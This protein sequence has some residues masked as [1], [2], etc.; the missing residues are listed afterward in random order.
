MMSVTCG[1]KDIAPFQGLIM[2]LPT[3]QG[4]SPLANYGAPLG[5][6]VRVFLSK[7]DVIF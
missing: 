1:T 7:F 2:V 5:L 6:S 3:I 4:A